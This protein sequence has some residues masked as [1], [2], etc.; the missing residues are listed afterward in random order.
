[1]GAPGYR[2][3]LIG[4]KVEWAP[5]PDLCFGKT[6]T[7]KPDS[8]C[9]HCKGKGGKLSTPIFCFHAC[10]LSAICSK[11]DGTGISARDLEWSQGG[12]SYKE[13]ISGAIC[14][15]CDGT[16]QEPEPAS[17]SSCSSSDPY[18]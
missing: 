14:T 11:C 18:A 8:E 12:F 4:A 10:D 13:P 2:C 3:E 1:M 9:S 16:G 6:G 5:C 15:N 7:C 17:D